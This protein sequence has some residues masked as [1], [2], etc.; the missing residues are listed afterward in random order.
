MSSRS[1]A[2]TWMALV[3]LLGPAGAGAAASDPLDCLAPHAAPANADGLRRVGVDAAA[4]VGTL[5]SFQGV[6]GAPAPGNHKPPGFTF[7]GWN[8]PEDVDVSPGYR[9]ARIDLV[10]THD[11]Y[12]PGDIDAHFAPRAAGDS[13]S[14]NVSGVVSG[15][16]AVRSAETL[17]RVFQQ[18][19]H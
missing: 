3:I 17:N 6:N 18:L 9:L 7:G 19:P 8:M 14:F 11:A 2:R 4:T 10:R 15:R 13:G 12:G 5:R 1:D 16:E